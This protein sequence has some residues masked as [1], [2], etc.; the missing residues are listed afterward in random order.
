MLDIQA[1]RYNNDTGWNEA[2][3]LKKSMVL[4]QRDYEF[5]LL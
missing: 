4:E 1:C 3:C 2:D 5:E